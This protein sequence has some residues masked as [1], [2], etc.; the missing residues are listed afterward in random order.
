MSS[1]VGTA[2]Y[3][4]ASPASLSRLATNAATCRRAKAEHHRQRQ[5]QLDR[6]VENRIGRPE[7]LLGGTSLDQTAFREN[8]AASAPHY[9]AWQASF[10]G[11]RI[12][13]EL[14]VATKSR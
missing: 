8:P 10:L 14:A 12:V 5:A 7:R 11:P 13:A 6:A 9:T 1:A 2:S 4:P 3:N